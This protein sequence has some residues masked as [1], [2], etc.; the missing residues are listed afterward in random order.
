LL[1]CQGALLPKFLDHL[2]VII[3]VATSLATPHATQALA[4]ES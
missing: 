1:L 3:V 2:V 4:R